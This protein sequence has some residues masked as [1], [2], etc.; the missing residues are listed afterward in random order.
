MY[1]GRIV[2]ITSWQGL[3]ED[4][5]HPYT[6]ALLSAVPIRTLSSKNGGSGS[7]WRGMCRAPSTLRRG[8]L[9]IRAVIGRRENAKRLSLPCAR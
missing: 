2:E 7:F 9:F 1:L 8:V 5:L 4:P 3:Y 6:Q